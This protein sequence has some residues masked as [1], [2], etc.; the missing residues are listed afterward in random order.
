MKRWF[1]R[2]DVAPVGLDVGALAPLVDMMTLLLVFLLRTYS[3]ELAPSPPSGP[4][5]LGPT[6]SEDARQGGVEILVAVD[7]I[8]VDGQ[9]IAAWDY[10]GTEGLVR[11]LYDR[12]LASRSKARVEVHADAAVTW[13]RLGRVFATAQAAGVQDLA[14]VGAYRG[15]L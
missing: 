12:L 7:A 4:F 1:A 6:V 9:R 8:Y 10:V 13:A 2:H 5:E 15:S 3:T 14:L 11:P